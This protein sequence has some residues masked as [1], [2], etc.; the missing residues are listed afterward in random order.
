MSGGDVAPDRAEVGGRG[1]T[2]AGAFLCLGNVVENS[3][4]EDAQVL[5]LLDLDVGGSF[6]ECGGD[7]R[8]VLVGLLR[9]VLL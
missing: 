7:D 2:A 1:T 9:L 8:K 6:L 3:G 4:G 5:D